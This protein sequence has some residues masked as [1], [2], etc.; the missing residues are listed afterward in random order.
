[1]TGAV[2]PIDIRGETA[3]RVARVSV[4]VLAGHLLYLRGDRPRTELA[5][6]CV[7]T[8]SVIRAGNE[9]AQRPAVDS[10]NWKD[11]YR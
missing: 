8:V 3:R 2:A 6:F 7:T 1:M 10:L 11:R 4:K 9:Y 5:R